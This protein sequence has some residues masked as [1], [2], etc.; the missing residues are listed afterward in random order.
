MHIATHDSTDAVRAGLGLWR[1]KWLAAVCMLCLLA[2]LPALAGR[3]VTLSWDAS[4]DTNVVDYVVNYGVRSRLYSGEERSRGATSVTIKNLGDGVTYYFT[5]VAVNAFGAMSD[6]SEEI[7]FADPCAGRS[8]DVGVTPIRVGPNF[9]KLAFETL[10]NR[11]YEV[12]ATE[13]FTS[14]VRV[15]GSG[16]TGAAGVLEVLDSQFTGTRRRFY[17]AVMAGPFVELP[18]GLNVLAASPPAIGNTL[19]FEAAVGRAYEVQSSSDGKRWNAVWSSGLSPTGGVVA[20]QDSA[21]NSAAKRYRLLGVTDP[22]AAYGANCNGAASRAPSL[23]TPPHQVTYRD[24]PTAPIA[25][26]VLDA[27]SPSQSL[28]LTAASSNPSL[29]KDSGFAFSGAGPSRSLIITPARGQAGRCVVEV[30]ATDGPNAAATAFELEVLPFTPTQFPVVVRQHG[31]GTVTPNLH[32]QLLTPG[33]TY[34]MKAHPAANHIFG[35]W[36]GGVTSSAPALRFVMQPN[37]ALE[38]YFVPNPFPATQG[39]YYALALE[40]NTFRHDQSGMITLRVS[41]RGTYSGKAVIGGRA[42]PFSGVLDAKLASTTVI[43]RKGA[44]SFGLSFVMGGSAS[45]QIAGSIIDGTNAIPFT[46]HRSIF[47][48]RSYPAPLVGAWTWALPGATNVGAAPEGWSYGTVK[49]DADGFGTF[50]GVMADGSRLSWKTPLSPRGRWPAFA[51]LYSGG[52]SVMSWL[53]LTNQSTN[54]IRGD[55]VWTK[56][57]LAKARLHPD[58]FTHRAPS[59][60]SR[61][62]APVGEM[63]RSMDIE[64]GFVIWS[65]GNLSDPVTTAFSWNTKNKVTDAGTNRLSLSFSQTTGLFKGTVDVPKFES[66]WMFGGVVLQQRNIAVGFAAG[67]NRTARTLVAP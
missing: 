10:P 66:R 21:T 11:K 15:G 52:G 6:P 23:S 67:T 22:L 39:S 33:V 51:S 4:L 40:T 9:I 65:G 55:V 12:Q 48:A 63:K 32:G 38:A 8:F 50:A 24:I 20:V 7:V 49:V 54:H 45:D 14:W 16:I 30:I 57:P 3:R 17:R 27:D 64:H 42:Y 43:L 19:M 41:S 46:G 29:V 13:D 26:T 37:L 2:T 60:G 61:Y 25:F 47:H 59:I 1:F 28:R 36:L 35:G 34:S 5:V 56:P 62:V 18:E 58:P 31:P 53:T 44:N